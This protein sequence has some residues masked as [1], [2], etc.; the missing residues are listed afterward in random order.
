MFT[1]EEKKEA[2]EEGVYYDFT[3]ATIFVRWTAFFTP[4]SANSDSHFC[5]HTCTRSCLQPHQ[6]A[7]SWLRT[8][9]GSSLSSAAPA[10][11][12]LAPHCHLSV[13]L[14]GTAQ[15]HESSQE[16]EWSHWGCISIQC[17]DTQQLHPLY[18][19]CM[20]ALSLTLVPRWYLTFAPNDRSSWALTTSPSKQAQ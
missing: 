10:A 15:Q 1:E 4:T 12:W 18:S 8:V 3:A 14:C 17:I 9:R 6:F 11:L 20:W 13:A 7:P 16:P 5:W 19:G 2:R